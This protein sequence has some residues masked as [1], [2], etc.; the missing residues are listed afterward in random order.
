[1]LCELGD[2]SISEDLI[3]G[4]LFGH[5]WDDLRAEVSK[6]HD[7]LIYGYQYSY[8][9]FKHK[10]IMIK[11]RNYS[12]ARIALKPPQAFRTLTVLD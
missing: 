11:T 7:F 10:T 9:N 2:P 3:V 6:N 12:T 4:S 8:L 1:M 5:F